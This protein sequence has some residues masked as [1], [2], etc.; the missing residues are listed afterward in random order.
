MTAISIEFDKNIAI[1]HGLEVAIIQGH[2][3]FCRYLDK[4]Q[5]EF[6]SDPSMNSICKYFPWWSRDQICDF[7]NYLHKE[8]LI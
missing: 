8:E 4:C 6:P 3:L 1:E 2:I 5:D 7:V